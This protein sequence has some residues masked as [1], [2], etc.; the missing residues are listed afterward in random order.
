MFDLA[1]LDASSAPDAADSV[2]VLDRIQ[3]TLEELADAGL[4]PFDL[5][6][7]AIPAPYMIPLTRII[8]PT[9]AMAYGKHD[10]LAV[11]APLAQE[12]MRALR[13]LKAPDYYG[14][15]CPANYF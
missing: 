6:S 2:L 5:D 3:Q 9:L 14:A 7:D 4:I 1:I 11:Y 10:K 12:G 13:R 8:V 15:V